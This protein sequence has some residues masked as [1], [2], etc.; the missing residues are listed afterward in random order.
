VSARAT[1]CDG[2]EPPGGCAAGEIEDCF[3][4]CCP[5]N[6][7]GDGY[8]DD[9]TYSHN[10][11]PIYLN[12]EEFN[13]DGGDCPPES[14]DGGGDPTGGCCVGTSCSVITQAECNAMGGSYLGDN[15]TCAGDPCGGGG[16]GDGDACGD[17]VAANDGGNAFDTSSNSDSGFGEPDESQCAGTYLDWDGSPDFWFTWTAAGNGTASFSTCDAGS[18][19]TSLV[20]YQGS[21]CSSLSQVACNGDAAPDGSCQQYHSQVDGLP[22][23]SGQTFYIR[24]GGWQAATGS[25]TLTITPDYGGGGDPTGGC[26]VGT[27]C[28][29]GTEADCEAMGGS[30]LGDNSSCTGN[31]C[32]GGGGG[33][34]YLE[35]TGIDSVDSYQSPNNVLQTITIP[36]GSNIT[37]VGWEDVTLSAYDP[38]WGSEA[39]IMF[40]WENDGQ[41]F[42]GY[43]LI[44]GEDTAPGD[45][46]PSTDF[47]DLTQDWNFSDADGEIVV[48][49]FETYDDA[50][51]V[52]DGQWTGGRIYIEHDG[53][54][55]DPTGG[56]CVGYDCSVGTAA[57]CSAMGGDYLG[58]GSSCSGDP[59]GSPPASGGC[60][61][62][63]ECSIMTA[64]DCAAFGGS[65]LGDDSDCSGNPCDDPPATGACCIGPSCGVATQADCEAAGGSYYGDGSNCTDV[66]CDGGGG[67]VDVTHVIS[68]T[69]LVSGM[70][71]YTVDLYITLEAGARLDAVAGTPDQTKT[72]TSS[73]DFYQ[74]SLGG[75]TSDQVNPALYESYPEL[76]WDSRVTIGALDSSG[77]PHDENNLQYIGIDWTDFE[78]GNDLS[79]DNGLWFVL[80]EEAQGE[81]M[82]FTAQDCTQQYGV[83]IARVTTIGSDSEIGF[84]GVV[85]GRDALGAL[86]QETVETYFGY[87]STEDCNGNMVP[88]ACDIANGTSDDADGNGIPDEC[89]STCP[90]DADGDG[91][92]DV[93]DILHVI[94]FFGLG[95]GGDVN[96]DGV[97]D[98]DDLLQVIASFGTC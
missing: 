42:A 64:D 49:F 3:G 66:T 82:M 21:S 2:D 70:E 69:N 36:A 7:V 18:F 23:S 90:G 33:D 76:E 78:A 6:W 63:T 93:D 89:D 27:S 29:V 40:N 67:G 81:A 28:S 85:Q 34:S 20:I 88:D 61:I 19:D 58:D 80:P 13:C 57:A 17:A 45:F 97:T 39:G 65:Y 25:G 52:V 51:G 31:P 12:C 77:N 96:G 56:C 41:P 68:G 72:L 16:G 1:A 87:T 48:E 11:V 79:A 84:S 5:A 46:G 59:C 53:D 94:S 55:G 98:V 43:I 26:C 38:S 14:C 62:N 91:D 54:G 4:N 35:I 95:D 83:L 50:E 24:L 74:H 86:Y 15:S 10:G 9:G 37:G 32:G 22:V 30:Y 71:T 75:S 44:F 60:C 92:S 47:E 8:C 73:G